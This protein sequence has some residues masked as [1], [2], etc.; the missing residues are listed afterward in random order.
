M[1]QESPWFSGTVEALCPDS[2]VCD[3][4]VGIIRSDIDASAR[5][6]RSMVF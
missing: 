2:L 6:T 3:A 4:F 1:P 5:Q